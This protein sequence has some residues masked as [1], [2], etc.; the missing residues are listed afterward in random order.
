MPRGRWLVYQRRRDQIA[1]ALLYSRSGH[2]SQLDGRDKL[3]QRLSDKILPWYHRYRGGRQQKCAKFDND[4]DNI[5]ENEQDVLVCFVIS[6]LHGVILPCTNDLH[7]RSSLH[8]KHGR[9]FS[10]NYRNELCFF[11]RHDICC[12]GQAGE[13]LRSNDLFAAVHVVVVDKASIVRHEKAEQ[14]VLN[15]HSLKLSAFS[16]FIMELGWICLA[17]HQTGIK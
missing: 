14:I 15:L 12:P 6:A 5:W 4:L 10:C 1:R 11:L 13:N 17:E 16:Y 3:A 8:R 2:L 9:S 7:L